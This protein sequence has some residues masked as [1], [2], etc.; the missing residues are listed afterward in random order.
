MSRHPASVTVRTAKITELRDKAEH[1]AASV[2]D[3]TPYTLSSVGD[4]RVKT[5]RI[6]VYTV[7]TV[8]QER[9]QFEV[10]QD[11]RID[12][13]DPFPPFGATV[14]A[15]G[16]TRVY[17]YPSLLEADAITI[18]GGTE[19]KVTGCTGPAWEINCGGDN[20][21]WIPNWP[22]PCWEVV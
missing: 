14:R 10:V 3:G 11:W 12:F 15:T 2:A 7:G 18:M 8:S 9:E 4:I 5:V 6:P 17:L 20:M 13:G 22:H 19:A 21:A 16:M 1:I